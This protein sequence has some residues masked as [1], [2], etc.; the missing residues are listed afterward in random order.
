MVTLV[1]SAVVAVACGGGSSWPGSLPVAA[2][3]TLLVALALELVRLGDLPGSA[4]DVEPV[5]VAV[6][7]LV[8]AEPAAALP[9]PV[10]GPAAA[11]VAAVAASELVA[12]PAAAA[13]PPSVAVAFVADSS[14]SALAVHHE[15]RFASALLA[16]AAD[17]AVAAAGVGVVLALAADYAG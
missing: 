13:G 15:L 7:A 4:A 2:G 14:D 3:S 6:H 8:A 1:A 17:A 11:V 9:E 10:A 16:V 5:A 12:G